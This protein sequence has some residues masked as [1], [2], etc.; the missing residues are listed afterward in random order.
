M[1]EEG[2][3]I[4]FISI[5]RKWADITTSLPGSAIP[6]HPES[7]KRPIWFPDLHG[8]NKSLKFKSPTFE[9]ILMFRMFWSFFGSMNFINLLAFFSFSTK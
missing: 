1:I 5:F 7:D 6:G 9:I 2:P 3:I 4:G 8:S